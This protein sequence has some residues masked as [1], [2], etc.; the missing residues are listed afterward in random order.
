MLLEWPTGVVPTQ[1]HSFDPKTWLLHAKEALFLLEPSLSFQFD[2]EVDSGDS[3]ASLEWTA[4]YADGR[5][6]TCMCVLDAIVDAAAT[7]SRMLSHL[8][9][10]Y[11][12]LKVGKVCVDLALKAHKPNMI[13]PQLLRWRLSMQ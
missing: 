13:R 7:M 8:C 1:P 10:S 11:R 3:T 12:I 5:E 4:T 6:I 2:V 9:H